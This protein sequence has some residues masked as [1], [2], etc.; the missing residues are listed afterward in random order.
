MNFIFTH[1]PRTG[2]STITKALRKFGDKDS[3][4]NHVFIEDTI[5]RIGKEKYERLFSFSMVR[6]PWDRQVSLYNY[7][8]RDSA[9]H[10]HLILTKLGSFKEY[11]KYLLLKNSCASWNQMEFIYSKDGKKLVNFVGRYEIIQ[12]DFK[13]ICGIIDVKASIPIQTVKEYKSYYDEESI[14]IVGQVFQND[15]KEF[16]YSYD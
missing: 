3:F 1:I 14:E 8:S 15:I 11:I 6:N 4:D 2:G 13:I 9:H 12:E 5:K 16:G 7:I 10:L